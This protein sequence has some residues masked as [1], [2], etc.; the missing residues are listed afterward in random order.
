MLRLAVGV[1]HEYGWQHK[2]GHKTVEH[3]YGWQ[4]KVSRRLGRAIMS[5]SHAQAGRVYSQ[6]DGTEHPKY[7]T[8]HP[9]YTGSS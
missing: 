3:E 7:P 6:H 9:K 5:M 1:E 4:H 8:K 2:V